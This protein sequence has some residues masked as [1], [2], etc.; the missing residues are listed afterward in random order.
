M[1]IDPNES[2]IEEIDTVQTNVARS[3]L[4][5]E[6]P[7]KHR[8]AGRAEGDQLECSIENGKKHLKWNNQIDVVLIDLLLD[9][10]FKGQKIGGSFTSSTYRAVSNAV[11]TKFSQLTV[12]WAASTQLIEATIGI[13]AAYFKAKPKATH[14]PHT[15]IQDF[16][17]LCQLFEKDR[18]I[19]C[20]VVGPKEK[21]LRWARQQI[22]LDDE[23]TN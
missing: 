14:F 12:V 3:S 19:G 13:W 6:Y 1:G 22:L 20:L 21:Q 4:A 9:Q 17:K 11:S 7:G 15:P 8:G 16:H 2:L 10:M 5:E 18:A 23:N